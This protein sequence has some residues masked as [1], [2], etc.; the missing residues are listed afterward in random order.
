M[1][2]LLAIRPFQ[3]ILM[4]V[5]I[6]MGF[7]GLFLFANYNGSNNGK[8]V[9]TVVIWGTVSRAAVQAELQQINLT[10]K[11]YGKVSYVQQP[12]DSFDVDLAN[13]IASGRGPDLILLSQEQLAGEESKLNLI[14]FSNAVPKRSFVDSTYVPEFSLYAND[15][16]TY[17]IPY[18]LDPLVLFYN[19]TIVNSA[20]FTVPSTR[21]NPL[22][23]EAIVGLAPTLSKP[24]DG[25]NFSQ[26]TIPFGTYS[27]VTDARGILSLLFLQ[28]GSSIT[29]PTNGGQRSTLADNDSQSTNGSTPA[30]SALAFYTQF[31]DPSRT[32]YSWNSSFTS[33]Q[34]AFL[35]GTLAF[36]VGYASEI[37]T[38]QKGNPNL[39]FDIA[40]IPQPQTGKAPKD[41]GLAYAFAIPKASGNPNGAFA[42]A[43][44]L[45]D[46]SFEPVGAQNLSMAP[47]QQSLLVSAPSDVYS[48]V[49]YPLALISRGWLSPLPPAVDQVFSAMIT[50]VT[51][52]RYSPS[53]AL[54]TAAQAIDAAYT[55]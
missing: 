45:S 38:I 32:V 4:V 46:K 36:Y 48:P 35:G 37:P 47:A 20:G 28:S 12:A 21:E 50:N 42:A 13:A 40:A 41:Y 17:G 52:G 2:S 5:F 27:N 34:Q 3:L 22:S 54:S 26:S 14:P 43:L 8:Q 44:A 9:G 11:A 24:I 29:Q 25:Q 7:V 6:L 31:S 16:G 51:S 55:Q 23:W 39:D 10:N 19:K 33:D 30:Q 1:K 15:N 53:T 49:Y 18:V